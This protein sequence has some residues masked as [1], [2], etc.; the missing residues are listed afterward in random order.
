VSHL[1]VHQDGTCNGLQH[2]AA[3][4]GDVF[5]A[6]EVNLVP[7]D[8][9][10]D[11]YSAIS[12]LVA[13]RV[14]ADAEKGVRMAVLLNGKIERKIVK[15]T[16]MTSVYGVTFVGARKQI[17]NALKDRKSVSEDEQWE[18]SQYIAQLTFASLKEM[19]SGARE[20]MAWLSESASRI[21]K[22]GHDVRWRTPLGLEVIQPYKKKGKERVKTITQDIQLKRLDEIQVNPMKQKSAFPP[23]YIHSLDS[24]HMMLTAVEMRNKNLTFASVHDSF[25]THAN[26]VNTLNVVLREKFIELHGQRLLEE[27][28]E[29]F[30]TNFPDVE[31]PPLPAKGPL[32][33]NVVSESKYFFN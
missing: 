21:A 6:K 11:V 12:D 7:S 18:A 26:S 17:A 8:A 10:Q 20:I 15:Q 32:D 29:Y 23:N 14:A 1:P 16:V 31:L 5:G 33:L 9:P 4:G 30:Q 25:W 24:T 22:K 2:Y 13:K 28:M 19:F 27:L 3:L